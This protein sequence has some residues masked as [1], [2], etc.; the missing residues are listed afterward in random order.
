[1]ATSGRSQVNFD[2]LLFGG[3]YAFINYLKNAQQWSLAD[4]SGAPDPDDLD[5]NG[6]PTTIVGGGVATVFFIPDAA[7]RPGDWVVSWSGT[8][9]V[10]CTG[11]GSQSGTNGRH[12]FS[13]SSGTTSVAFQITANTNLSNLAFYQLDEETRYLSGEIFNTKFLDVMGQSRFAVLRF[14]NWQ[15]SNSSNVARWADRRPTTYAYYGGFEYRAADYGGST[16]GSSTAYTVSAPSSWP[17]LVDKARVI[18]RFHTTATTNTPTLAVGGTAAKT[19]KTPGAGTL[20]T[21]QRPQ[22]PTGGFIG[23]L[24]TLVYD[25]DLDCW[26]KYGGDVEAFDVGGVLSGAP[27]ETCVALCNELNC[28]PWFVIPYLAADGS[29]VLPSLP[30]FT[31]QL[32]TYCEA[33]LNVGLV[34]RFEGPNE[35]WNYAFFPTQYADAK[36]FT[37]NGGT[38]FDYHNWYGTVISLIGQAVSAV[39]S[40]D[41]DLYQIICGFQT[42]GGQPTARIESPVYVADGGSA[43]ENWVTHI[44]VTGYYNSGYYGQAQE[45][46]WANEYVTAGTARQAEIIAAYVG[47]C[48]VGSLGSGFSLPEVLTAITPFVSFASSYG[49]KLTQYEGGYSPD[50]SGGANVDTLRHDSKLLSPLLYDYTLQN[51]E[52]FLALN[53]GVCEYPSHFDLSGFDGGTSSWSLFDPNIYEIPNPQWDAIVEFNSGN[54]AVVSFVEIETR[55]T[56]TIQNVAANFSGAGNLSASLRLP[57]RIS[58]TFAGAGALSGNVTVV[59][60]TN[61]HQVAGNFAGAGAL[62][63]SLRQ[64]M[65]VRATFAGAGALTADIRSNKLL[66]ATFA[67]AGALAA[68]LN[69]RQLIAATFN[70]AGALVGDVIVV[71]PTNAHQVAALFAGAGGLSASLRQGMVVQA[72]YAGAGALTADVTKY[73]NIEATFQGAGQLSASL[74]QDLVVQAL[75]NGAGALTASITSVKNLS[76][77]FQGAGNL[78]AFL[79]SRM[80]VASNFAGTG[81]LSAE[82]LVPGIVNNWTVAANFTGVGSLTVPLNMRQTAAASFAG[83]GALT[84]TI[85]QGSS[86]SASFAGAGFLTSTLLQQMSVRAAFQGAGSLSADLSKFKDIAAAFQGA[87]TLSVALLQQLAMRATFQG[88]GSLTA[89]VISSTP[90]NAHAIAATFA[91]AGGLNALLSLR[92]PITTVFAGAGSLAAEVRVGAIAWAVEASF[93]GAGGLTVTLR[94][95]Q[96]V[97]ATFAGAGSLSADLKQNMGLAAVFAGAGALTVDLSKFKQ[98]AATFAGAG[99]LTADISKAKYVEASFQGAG[100]LAATLRQQMAVSANFAGAGSLL[101]S[102]RLSMA[103]TA[104]FDGAGQLSSYLNQGVRVAARF[105]GAGAIAANV[106][107]VT[108]GTNPAVPRD[109]FCTVTPRTDTCTANSRT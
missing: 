18:V 12:Q 98:I 102:L 80:L 31:T 95:N 106:V 73:K 23:R 13:I 63:A 57:Q 6:Y 19:I 11:M 96:A 97:S 105:D 81:S 54:S 52:D 92:L 65:V 101:A 16:G 36:E 85:N 10:S 70:G 22:G 47:G 56:G 43:A 8:G 28:H 83:S 50:T 53:P 38:T 86:I 20:A 46:T 4:N 99:T 55:V 109:D 78:T 33:N 100:L 66:T 60:P 71:T 26:L 39:Y 21:V 103:I 17:G 32:A 45:T 67:G 87:G 29:G 9:T 14:L 3:E 15:S 84:A 62:T 59:T 91:G 104:R 72:T 75:F 44:A 94:L 41:R 82:I 27:I 64:G 2:F 7:V 90:S 1:M 40:D 88:A 58:A 93:V 89:E 49:L 74:R 30:D 79:N 108:S 77:N 24:G 35:L 76:A 42:Y 69:S 25:A 51:Y 34:P 68:T 107:S 5:S 37:R 61:I 48:N